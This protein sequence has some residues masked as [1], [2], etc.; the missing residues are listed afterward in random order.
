MSAVAGVQKTGPRKPALNSPGKLPQWSMCACDRITASS[1]FWLAVKPFVLRASLRAVALEEAAIEKDATLSG[2]EQ[3]LTAGDF[4]GGSEKRQ[5]HG[6]APRPN[7]KRM[8]PQ[9]TEVGWAERL[10]SFRTVASYS[11]SFSFGLMN[12]QSVTVSPSA[13]FVRASGC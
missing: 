5:L 4:A 10:S 7:E 6:F 3:M 12:S 2:F 8:R 13:S 9:R 1:F 11:N